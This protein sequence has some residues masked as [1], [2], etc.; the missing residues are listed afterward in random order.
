MSSLD[1]D[2]LHRV[3]EIAQ[4]MT[5]VGAEISRVE[6]SVTRM[7]S[8]YGATRVDVY[9]TTSNIIVSAE[10]AEGT[11]ITQTRRIGRI[12]N[13]MERLHRYNDLVRW[14]S[15]EAPSLSAVCERLEAVQ[16]SPRYPVWL[17]VLFSGVIGA[18]FC[19]FFGGRDYREV[20]I[21]FVI[22][23]AIG[24]LSATLEKGKVNPILIRFVCAF[25][26]SAV[27]MAA[28]HVRWIGLPDYILI[29]NIMTLI[30]G[31]GITNAL[32]DLFSGDVMT[33][34]LRSIEAVL[35]TLA[36]ALGIILPTLIGGAL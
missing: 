2:L 36:I 35:L 27:T 31:V 14:V 5:E 19:L 7:C 11:V 29:G 28:L 16:T 9:A 32:R 23:A 17:S 30:P 12:V 3:M 4:Q 24:G 22:G 6:E 18:S 20:L 13:D 34:I 15:T 10:D 26:A 8:A 25:F 21:A 33:G 1:Q